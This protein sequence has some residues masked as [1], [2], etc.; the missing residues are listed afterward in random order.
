MNHK[1]LNI[2]EG[3]KMFWILKKKKIKWKN[4][5]K[6]IPEESQG[7]WKRVSFDCWGPGGGRYGNAVSRVTPRR[8]EEE[9]GTMMNRTTKRKKRSKAK[10]KPPTLKATFNMS[11][12]TCPKPRKPK[13]KQLSQKLATKREEN[14]RNSNSKSSKIEFETSQLTPWKFKT[15]KT[16]QLSN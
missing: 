9:R 3:M 7:I 4:P 14:R 13:Q 2:S 6:R 11:L 10:K 15:L 16:S 1:F 8:E 12:L 5:P